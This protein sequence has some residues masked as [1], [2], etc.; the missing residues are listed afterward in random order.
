IDRSFTLNLGGEGEAAT[1]P[2]V[3]NIYLRSENVL[4][5]RNILGVYSFTGSAEDSGWLNS[6]FGRDNIRNLKDSRGGVVPAGEEELAF[7]DQYRA[8][9]LAPGFFALPRR[10]Y[11]GAVIEF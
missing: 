11:L 10:V 1:R 7:I 8:R 3:L 9:L 4:N 2:I 5:T 6:S